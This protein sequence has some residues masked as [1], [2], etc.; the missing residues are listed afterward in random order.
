DVSVLD[1]LLLP[2]QVAHAAQAVFSLR[3][4]GLTTST[5][6]PNSRA[7]ECE[8]A[9]SS[10]IV[11]TTTMLDRPRDCTT[12]PLHQAPFPASCK[13][14][15]NAVGCKPDDKRFSTSRVEICLART[16][17]RANDSVRPTD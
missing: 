5:S 2:A 16:V 11:A 13:S 6:Y 17:Q 12:K 3:L 7:F 4:A 9:L 8:A 10:G 14:R 1:A 15:S